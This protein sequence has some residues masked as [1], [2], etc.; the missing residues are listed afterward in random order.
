MV[1]LEASVPYVVDNTVF[2]NVIVK[3]G[4]RDFLVPPFSFQMLYMSHDPL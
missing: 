1:C 4:F 3:D 2:V